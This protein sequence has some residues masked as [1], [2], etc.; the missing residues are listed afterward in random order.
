MKMKEMIIRTNNF[1]FLVD[2]KDQKLLLVYKDYEIRERIKER[3][4][5]Y[6]KYNVKFT[7]ETI[8][9]PEPMT[10]CD[11]WTTGG[12]YGLRY[13]EISG[14]KII[15]NDMEIVDYINHCTGTVLKC[16]DEMMKLKLIEIN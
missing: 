2:E 11:E 6:L 14:M 7:E 5:I 8:E 15:G 9:L 12:E 10:F 1:W 13:F 16:L 3:R 4:P